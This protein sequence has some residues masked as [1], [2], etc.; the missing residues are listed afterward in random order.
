M[1]ELLQVSCK[2]EAALVHVGLLPKPKKLRLVL[3][4]CT[5]ERVRIRAGPRSWK[6]QHLALGSP[7]DAAAG[8]RR[9]PGPHVRLPL[10]AQ[11][12][13]GALV[14]D[15]VEAPPARSCAPSSSEGVTGDA[16]DAPSPQSVPELHSLAPRASAEK[17]GAT[18]TLSWM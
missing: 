13:Q 9:V 10:A 17:P 4:I 11:I 12:L 3:E 18:A 6:T 14:G 2:N 7:R 5:L 1:L 16:W 8:G 15:G